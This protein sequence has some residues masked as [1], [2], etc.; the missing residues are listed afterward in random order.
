[1]K[2]HANAALS[3]NGRRRMVLRVVEQGWSLTQAAEAAEVSDRTCRKWVRR[4]VADGEVGLLD[5]PSAPKTVHNRTDEL[6]V[7]AIAALRRLRFTGPEIAEVLDRPLSTVSG[8]LTRIG[9]GRLGRLGLEPV[10]RYE[11]QRPGEL[12]H[13]DVKKL[14]RILQPGH[15]MTGDRRSRRKTGRGPTRKGLAGWE[16][17]HI[18]T[19]LAYVELRADEKA[20]TA[21]EFLGRAL[22]FFTS[23]GMTIERVMTDNGGA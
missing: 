12:I 4:Y 23:Y 15:R 19:R 6:A 20:T 2:Q 3:L 17:V 18:A 22:A 5:R 8:I 13:I 7:A 9:M 11:R 1:M 16:F 10:M 14:G 21:T